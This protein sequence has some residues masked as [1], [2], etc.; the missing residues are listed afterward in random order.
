[1]LAWEILDSA[2]VPG[3]P[4]VMRL[5]RRGSEF[6]IRVDDRE[7]MASGVHGSED[8]LADLSCARIAQRENARILIGGLGMG[9]TL[10]AAVRALNDDA[11]ILVAELVPAIAQWNQTTIG[12][13]AGH[14]L[15]DPRV[16]LILGDVADT[17]RAESNSLDAILLDVDNGPSA[18]SSPDNGWLYEPRG[19]RQ[20]GEALRP[21]GILA[22]WSAGPDRSFTSRLSRAGF[23]VSQEE[24]RS[25]GAKGGRRHVIW[26]ATRVD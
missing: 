12:H 20:A 17:L 9:Y 16:R 13:L 23:R 4:G 18:L 21:G 22:V 10:A 6:S 26:L 5:Y 7:L 19:L 3:G 25:R 2:P 14:P 15:S 8:A 1:M 11:Q 24:V